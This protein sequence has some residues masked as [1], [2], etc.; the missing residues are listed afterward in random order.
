[1]KKIINSK[2]YDTSTAKE[3][4]HWDNRQYGS[5][6]HC[7]EILYRKRTGEYFIFGEG[8]A[9]S[10]YAESRGNNN[11]GGGS[12]I[13]PLTYDA[14]RA[15]GEEHMSSIDYEA[16]FGA[17]AEDDSRVTT[18]ISLSAWAFESAKRAAAKE[19]ISI[20]GYIEALIAQKASS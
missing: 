7:E 5:L 19:G 1:M 10:K 16:E 15:W 14:A 18:S 13:I 6:D 20:S 11:W 12:Q 4:A 9:G 2:L 3:V 17:V 8:G